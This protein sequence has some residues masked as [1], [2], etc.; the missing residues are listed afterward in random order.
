MIVLDWNSMVPRDRIALLRRAGYCDDTRLYRKEWNQ[1][2]S[3]Q[4]EA[5]S[6]RAAKS[7]TWR[8]KNQCRKD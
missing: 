1:L 8:L 4:Q 2:T 7:G 3:E 6:V 5:L